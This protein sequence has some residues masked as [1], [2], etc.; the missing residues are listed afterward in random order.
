MLTKLQ[1]DNWLLHH[2]AKGSAEQV[3]AILMEYA[4]QTVPSRV[5]LPWNE[6]LLRVPPVEIIRAP[7]F[8]RRLSDE[9]VEGY[10]PSYERGRAGSFEH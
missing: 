6:G 4:E 9:S 1:V 5:Q 8:E 3:F 2:G 10:A 7:S